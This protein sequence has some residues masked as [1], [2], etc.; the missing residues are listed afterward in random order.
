[1]PI[2]NFTTLTADNFDKYIEDH[3]GI[4]ICHKHLCPH[5]KI[6]ATVLDKVLAMAENLNVAAEEVSS[7]PDMLEKLSVEHVPTLCTV[8]NGKI[9]AR[10]FGVMNPAETLAWYAQAQG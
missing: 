7:Q 8:K 6:M 2:E 4:I 10:R 5:C 3:D 9:V 1:M